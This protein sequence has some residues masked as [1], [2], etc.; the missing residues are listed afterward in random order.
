MTGHDCTG[1]GCGVCQA[2]IDERE[3]AR[4]DTSWHPTGLSHRRADGTWSRGSD[5]HVLADAPRRFAGGL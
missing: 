5:W 4:L 2:A 3:T 1:E